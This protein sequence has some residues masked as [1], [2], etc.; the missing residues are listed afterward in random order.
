M[1]FLSGILR[2]HFNKGRGGRA[3]LAISA[4]LLARGAT[5]I[6]GLAVLPLSIRHLGNEGYGLMAMISSVVGW[7]QISNLGLGLGLQNALTEEIAKG[8]KAAQRQLIS[9]AFFALI[10]I[11]TLLLIL[12]ALAFPLIDWLKVFPP[13]TEQYSKEIP[14]AVAVCFC[15]LVTTLTLGPILPIYAARQ[16]L[17]LGSI[18]SVLS[19]L[20]TLAGVFI[21]AQ[22]GL[23][24]VGMIGA[25]IGGTA[26]VQLSFA[27]WTLYGRGIPE[28]RP[29][30]Q[31][32]SRTAWNRM[33]HSGLQFLIL[34]I[35]NIVFIQL[36]AMLIAHTLSADEVT[37][38][39]VAQK[40]FLQAGGLFG[41]I[42]GSLW[43]AYGHAKAHGDIAWI[44]S[45]HQKTVQLFCLCYGAI[46]IGMLTAGRPILSLWVG[47]NATPTSSLLAAVA[48]HFSLK[49]WTAL[50]AVLLNSLNLV[51]QQ[52]A[53]VILT[54]IVV[55]VLEVVLVRH[56]GT[57][58]L[59]LGGG[60]GF[61][62]VGGWYLR[63]LTNRALKQSTTG[64]QDLQ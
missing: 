14:W 28:L 34:Q 57:L 8:D 23:G 63:L 2:S 5:A 1:A 33:F 58:G 37:P 50:H 35:C 44:R 16:E 47:P 45:T 4:N 15:S 11:G 25:T 64:S 52:V 17:H 61:L 12:G 53:P 49:D 10:G 40:V 20:A 60:L 30:L 36:D 19:C 59:A 13:S 22:Y 41:M 39:A 27:L 18:Q 43:S 62:A 42:T 32:L 26:L 48:F 56:L 9:T 6:V 46:A 21:V 51:R 3:K 31:Y 55:L 38:Y 54:A 7:L 24:L 29:S